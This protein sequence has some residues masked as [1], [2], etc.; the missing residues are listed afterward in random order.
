MNNDKFE[1]QCIA[2]AGIVQA[3]YM[4]DKIAISGEFS[5]NYLQASANSIF[6]FNPS[7]SAEIFGGLSGVRLGLQNLIRIF[8]NEKTYDKSRVVRYTFALIQMQRFL[9][10]NLK[11][12][13]QMQEKLRSYEEQ[14]SNNSTPLS[15][16][17]CHG[18]AIYSETLGKLKFKIYVSGDKTFISRDN[19]EKIIR[20][21][22]LAG[23]RAAFLWQQ[24]GGRRWKLIFQR[25]NN[26]MCLKK[27]MVFSI[28]N[29]NQNTDIS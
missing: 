25:Q 15:E 8:S 27:L 11:M 13:D 2:I 6:S 1:E 4:V 22:L 23:V 12:L 29:T 3:A 7:S 28:Q 26:M 5:E 17:C 24:L 21:M 9:Q 14:F 10:R 20:T 19:N 18:S 16:L